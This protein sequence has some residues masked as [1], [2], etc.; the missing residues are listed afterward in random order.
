MRWLA[1]LPLAILP[2]VGFA[3]EKPTHHEAIERGLRRLEEGSASYLT[4]RQCFSCHH[5]A[6]SLA[7]F[8]EAKRA[9]FTVDPMNYTAQVETIENTYKP[10]VEQIRK[11]QGVGGA[12]ASAGWA[13]WTL[14]T[15]GHKGDEVSEAM[16]QYLLT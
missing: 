12:N 15:V 3:D 6:L 4:H 14:E 10:K 16:V 7:V 9:G 5:A 2:T 8:T 1:L 11:G 13:L